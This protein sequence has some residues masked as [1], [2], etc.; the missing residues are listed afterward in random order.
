VEGR[1]HSHVWEGPDGQ[2]RF[3]N[4]VIANTVVFLDR[5]PVA[6]AGEEG[7]Q[8]EETDEVPQG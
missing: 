1:L 3:R 8:E 2:K 7:A 4:E 6:P 5:Q